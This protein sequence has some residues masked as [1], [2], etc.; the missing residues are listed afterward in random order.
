MLM[1]QYQLGS[2]FTVLGDVFGKLEAARKKYNIEDYSVQQTTL[3]QVGFKN[4]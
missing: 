1:F 3:D 2:D 4:G